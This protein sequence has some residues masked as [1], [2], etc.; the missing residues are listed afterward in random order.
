[1]RNSEVSFQ[2]HILMSVNTI[3]AKNIKHIN[4]ISELIFIDEKSEFILCVW[5]VLFFVI[6]SEFF[7]SQKAL[8]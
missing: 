3:I 4:V 1:V 5:F 6:S 8:R 2:A 7:E